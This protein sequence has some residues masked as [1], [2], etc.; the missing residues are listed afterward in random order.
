MIEHITS[1]RVSG[2]VTSSSRFLVDRLLA[3]IDFERARTLVELGPGDGCVTREILQRMHPDARLVA[4]E[5]NPAFVEMGRR[6]PDPR[7]VVRQACAS[8]LPEVLREEGL[9]GVDAI[10]SSLPLSIIDDELVRRI[11]DVSKASL[12]PRGR[13][14]QYQYSLS[15]YS[16]LA[17]RYG[18][19]QVGFTLLN[20]PPAF[21]YACAMGSGRARRQP[22]VRPYVASFYA[23]ALTA[24]AML[25]RVLRGP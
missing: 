13:F 23:G 9:D 4:L 18:S 6:I 10:V 20:A 5:V 19:V 24:I 14:H 7:L 22:R 15:G 16:R 17:R 12:R 11:L 21:V 8:A 3:G 1:I 25:L 2:T